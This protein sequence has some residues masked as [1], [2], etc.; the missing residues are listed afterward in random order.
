[1]FSKFA[2]RAFRK[3]FDSEFNLLRSPLF[4][5]AALCTLLL[6]IVPISVGQST[7]NISGYV[8]DAT[9]AAL[10][11]ATVT[12]VMFEQS[13]KRTSLTD[14]DGFYNFIALPAGH[15]TLT[16]D[17]QG[18]Q[19]EIRSNLELTVAQNVRAD[20]QLSVG[21][22]QSEIRVMSAA[23]LVDTTSNT[24]SG[25]VDDRRVVD[26][27]LN[28]RNIMSLAGLLPGVT[29]VSAP[30]VMSDA[31][32]GPEMNVNGSL[33][34]S[35]VY[36]FDG[37]YFNNPS[38]NTGLNL[39]PPDAIA[40]FRM[41]TAN[42]SAEYGH[43]SGA[44]VE[45]VS[46]AGTDSF[47]GSAWEFLRNDAFNAKD[48]FAPNVPS[49]KQNQ[50]GI[51]IGG[52]IFKGK[53]FFFGAYQRLTDHGSAES[54][55]ALVPSAAEREGDFTGSNVSLVDPTD[56]IT[57][58]PLTDSSGTPCVVGNRIAPGCI[59]PVA[60]NLLKFVPESASGTVTSLA[61]SPITNNT[62]TVRLDWNQSAKNLI[63]GHYYQDNTSFVSPFSGYDG[64]N[65]AGYVANTTSI[66]TQNG[67]INDIYSFSPTLINQ[68]I[69][70]VLNTNTNEANNQ[71]YSNA[72]LGI[73]MPQYTPTGSVGVDVGSNF[74]LDS[75]YAIVFSGINYQFS[76]RL[77]WIKG[78]HSL[79]VGFEMLKLHFF[80]SFIAPSFF[81]FSGV[82][83]ND[84]TADFLLGA[85]D[86]ISINFGVRV[87]DDRTAYNSFYAKDDFRVTPRLIVNYGVRYEPFLQ[88]KDGNNNLNTIVPE[89]QSTIDPSAPPGVLFIGD[90][91]IG[92]GIAQ[93][94]LGNFAPRV[95]FA[96]DVFGDGKTSV[97]G[98]YGIFYNSVNANEVAQENPP[99]AGTAAAYNGDIA[100]PFTSTGVANPPATVSGKFGCTKIATYPFYSCSLFPLPI[101]G[102]LAINTTLH[103][104]RYQEYNFSLQRQINPTTMIEVSYVGN[105]GSDIHGRVPFNPAQFIADPITGAP[106]SA[107][108]AIDRVLYEPGILGPT[109]RIM[110]NF[111]H[112]SYNALQIQGTKR[113]GQGST[114][115]ANYTFAKSLDMNSTNNNNA[116]IPNPF[117]LHAGYGRSDSDRKNSFVVSWLYVLPIHFSNKA[118][119]SLLGGWSLTAIQT[120]QSG[121]PITFFAGR[122]VAVDG[123]GEKQYAQLQQGATA[124][125]IRISHPNRSSEV[126]RF[127]NTQAF[128]QPNDEPLGIYG[129]S[130]R[131]MISGPAYANTDASL[132][133]DFTLPESLKLQFRL[134]SF[135]TFNQ[136]NFANPNSSASS[137]AFGQ[138]QSTVA[139]TGRQLQLALKLLW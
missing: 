89:A 57:G 66:K 2:F 30:Q 108:N 130:S 20:A 123:T 18:F 54:G 41:L 138:I 71:T 102:M 6:T 97:R 10:S 118:A 5:V 81:S 43:S 100:N 105:V 136:V 74:V 49:E 46:R 104:P 111:A 87:N 53:A 128:V 112:S 52:P 132:L 120:V 93:S 51:A 23:P 80:Q 91:G 13:T 40:Q 22:V 26:L 127:F 59:S 72:S 116:N 125:T 3:E 7:G 19:R 21:A 131:G 77:S 109:N 55:Q 34:N 110:S 56:P 73:N 84:P 63:F 17:A 78:R 121:A 113:F 65:I 86:N 32:G 122:D 92:K 61:P 88:W 96:W 28:G 82:R 85:Y 70:S 99:Y 39:P 83:S 37:A 60:K 134:E 36:T 12:A 15:Y 124:S 58:L 33:P 137:G 16:F 29:N 11:N 50:Y 42:F 45:V 95:G 64:G 38:R 103:L 9:G 90:K 48:Y 76:D 114:I 4:M 133:K 98:G 126:N 31:R 24:L 44:Q 35:T 129:N 25:F 79:G 106:P 75:G 117:D 101:Q 115:L 68:A 107:G 135:N 1:M 94:N 27:P 69:F 139:Q 62:G 8:R 47:H 67:V 119:N 14:A